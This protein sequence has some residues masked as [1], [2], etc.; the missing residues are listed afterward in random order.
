MEDTIE[1]IKNKFIYDGIDPEEGISKEILASWTRSKD[2]GTSPQSLPTLANKTIVIDKITDRQRFVW[3]LMTDFHKTCEAFLDKIGMAVFYLNKDLEVFNKGGNKAFLSEL[4]KKKLCFGTCFSEE[5]I[6]T[7]AATLST[8]AGDIKCTI[9]H[10]H[11]SETLTDYATIAVNPIKHKFYSTDYIFIISPVELFTPCCENF[12]NHTLEQFKV[13]ANY[14]SLP[15][16]FIK[17]YVLTEV[18]KQNELLYLIVSKEGLIIEANTELYKIFGKTFQQICGKRVDLIFSEL[19]PTL[20][21]LNNRKSIN[22]SQITFNNLPANQ[23]EYILDCTPII[24]GESDLYGLIIILT[25]CKKIQKYCQ[26]VTKRG[27]FYTFD[28]LVGESKSFTSA[29]QFALLASQSPSTVLLTGESGTGKELFAQSI[30]NASPRKN[31]PF[32][33][34]NC[35]SIPKELIGSELFGY[36][37]GAFTGAK[38]NG[39]PGKFELAEE[40]TFFLDEITEMPLDMQAVL[41]R[42]LEDHTVTRLGSSNIISID[43]R[44][45]AATNRDLIEYVKLGK[46]RQDLYYRLNVLKIELPPLRERLADLPQLIEYFLKHFSKSFGKEVVGVDDDVVRLFYE[47][48]WPGNLRELRNVIERGIN[49][50]QSSTLTLN[51]IPRDLYETLNSETNTDLKHE[52]IFQGY[53]NFEANMIRNLL[54]KHRGNKSAVANEMN[55]SRKSLYNKLKKQKISL[56]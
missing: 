45:I 3:K 55:I 29:K 8:I 17:D 36:V 39:T 35:A 4:K 11:Y 26:K 51:D 2:H 52:D 32:I 16:V 18:M 31:K 49:A 46:F 23:N 13:L 50:T 24:K 1:T 25:N 20:K 47:Y 41:L 9:G 12:L 44:I 5:F 22:D 28:M 38:K 37:E 30:H 40:G 14:R 42:V 56:S 15:D 6:G 10:E 54:I 33:P 19:T 7:N 34:L 48:S 21:C 43:T 53:K 27:P